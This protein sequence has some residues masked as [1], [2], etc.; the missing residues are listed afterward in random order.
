MGHAEAQAFETSLIRDE[1][2]A[3]QLARK[4]EPEELF[5]LLTKYAKPVHPFGTRE[6]VLACLSESQDARAIE[7]LVLFLAPIAENDELRAQAA[8]LLA[9]RD[10]GSVSDEIFDLIARQVHHLLQIAPALIG[11]SRSGGSRCRATL[12][13][14]RKDLSTLNAVAHAALEQLDEIEK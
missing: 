6:R 13:G 1:E 8:A 11:V 10:C 2:R 12:E 3:V 4:L 14:L 7:L 9:D 5:P